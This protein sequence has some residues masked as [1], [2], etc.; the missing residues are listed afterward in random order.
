MKAD[1]SGNNWKSNYK[2][3]AHI[4]YVLSYNDITHPKTKEDANCNEQL[5]EC[6]R[7]STHRAR[8]H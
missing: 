4:T 8:Q 3:P 6:S 1:K 2:S 5:I 7:W